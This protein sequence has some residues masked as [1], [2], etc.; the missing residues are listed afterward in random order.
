MTD[1]MR[2]VVWETVRPKTTRRDIV[3]LYAEALT[4]HEDQDWWTVNRIIVC[5]WS[6]SGLRW[7]KRQAWKLRE[8]IIS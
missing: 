1:R 8:K 2:V 7:I 3:P 6:Q 4:D 5:H